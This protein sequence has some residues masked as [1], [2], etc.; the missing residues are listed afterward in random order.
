MDASTAATQLH[1]VFQMQHLVVEDVL[2]YAPGHTAVV[3]DFTDDDGVVSRV[4]VAE[5]VAGTFAAP[6]ELGSAHEPVEEA[7]VKV[8][9]DFFEVVVVAAGRV[10]MLAAAK[11]AHEP[12]FGGEVVAGDI[13]PV[14]G[15]VSPIDGLAVKLGEQD[16]RDCVENGI[17]RAFEDVGEA[18]I[19]FALTQANGVVDG[20]KRIEANVHGR[21]RRAG[22]HLGVG[23]V[24]D[25]GEARG[26]D[27]LR[28]AEEQVLSV[29]V[30][31]LR[32]YLSHRDLRID[33][34]FPRT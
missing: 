6:S 34:V 22:A 26:H 32:K 11:L 18:N 31:G 2:N 1:G 3:E 24:E 21:R 17:G 33:A 30:L 8:F 7:A 14:P 5:T 29:R 9:E 19:K 28:V 12:R 27:E 23:G 13:A 16:M 15:A 25:F 4:V 20:D 10:D